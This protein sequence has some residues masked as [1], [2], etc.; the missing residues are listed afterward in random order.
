MINRTLLATAQATQ[1]HR[2]L[3]LD[4]H[5]CWRTEHQNLRRF[6]ATTG[7]GL[8]AVARVVV[9]YTREILELRAMGGAR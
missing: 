6:V 4:Q 9:G 3:Q 2:A 1:L 8:R 7:T 5:T